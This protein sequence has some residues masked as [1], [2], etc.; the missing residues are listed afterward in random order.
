MVGCGGNAASM[1][2][3][4]FNFATDDGSVSGSKSAFSIRA[5]L[6]D[7]DVLIVSTAMVLN[8]A[9]SRSQCGTLKPKYCFH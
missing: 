4:S 5:S 9:K 6:A 8:C 7:S 1:A 3:A 2:D